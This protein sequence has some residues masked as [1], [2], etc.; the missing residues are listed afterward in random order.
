MMNVIRINAHHNRVDRRR[1]L[2]SVLSI[3]G[4]IFFT[5]ACTPA[6]GGAAT[7]AGV[8]APEEADAALPGTEE[9]GLTREELVTHIESVERLI[10]EC[11]S[12]AGFEYIAA[13]YDTVR[14]G[15]LAEKSLP[16]L[17]E[18]EF[19]D[20]YGFGI[21]TLYTGLGPQAADATN[22]ATIGLGEQN[23]RIFNGLSAAD[24]IAYNRAL[25]GEYIDATF[26]VTLE[27]EDFSRTGGCTRAAVEQVFSADQLTLAYNNPL[28]DI[29]ARDPRMITALEAFANC[30]RESGFDYNNPDDVENDIRTR[31][32]AITGGQ[33]PEALSSES[34]A[35][36]AELQG[37]ERAVGA[38]TFDCEEE[39]IIPVE[40]QILQELYARPVE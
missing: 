18:E 7:E 9:F 34:Q 21:S 32:D 1:L 8:T 17:S 30:I 5:A 23:V 2:T 33:P 16:G 25:F 38:V 4:L 10:A 28:D 12:E 26:A 19:I 15:M 24:Q 22:P 3:I 6:G 40:E 11:M 29:V 13:D 27:A 36:L 14:E 31:L 20:Q 35:A 37:L 39:I